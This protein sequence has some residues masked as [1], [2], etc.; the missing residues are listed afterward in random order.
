MF[1][2]SSH[3]HQVALSLQGWPARSQHGL[4]CKM[5]IKMVGAGSFQT[6]SLFVCCF[7]SFWGVERGGP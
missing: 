7:G 2:I 5:F 6:V 4:C 3:Q 1:G